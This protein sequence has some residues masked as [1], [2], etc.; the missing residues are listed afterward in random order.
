MDRHIM[1]G[2]PEAHKRGT[3]AYNEYNFEMTHRA[4][5][6]STVTRSVAVQYGSFTDANFLESHFVIYLKTH[7]DSSSSIHFFCFS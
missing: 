1:S 5:E 3:N 4:S 6:S 2:V 7:K